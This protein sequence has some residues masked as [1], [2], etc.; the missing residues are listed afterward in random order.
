MDWSF[1]GFIFFIFF[2]YL[3][4]LESSL[5]ASSLSVVLFLLILCVRSNLICMF[6]T[7]ENDLCFFPVLWLGIMWILVELALVL[8][9]FVR[10]KQ[11]EVI[12]KV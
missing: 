4:D 10:D 3:F 1:C 12:M 6:Q 2:P 5:Y 7:K 11:V 8:Y 9:E